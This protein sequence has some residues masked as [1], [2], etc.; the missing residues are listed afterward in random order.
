MTADA[1]IDPISQAINALCPH[2]GRHPHCPA[3]SF[4]NQAA[5]EHIAWLRNQ[6]ALAQLINEYARKHK[7]QP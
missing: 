6:H 2:N 4:R 7:R 5:I 3:C 1:P